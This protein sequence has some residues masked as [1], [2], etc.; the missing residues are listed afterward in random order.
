MNIEQIGDCSLEDR[1]ALGG[2]PL[3]VM[4]VT[5][6]GQKTRLIREE[7]RRVAEDHRDAK[8]YEV[9]LLENPSVTEKYSILNPPM[10]LMFVD[11]VE[12]GRHAGTFIATTIDR[13]LGPCAHEED[14][15]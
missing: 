11:G 6:E 9:D 7:F 8:F 5:S 12:V 14:E 4:F 15:T 3:V 10:T 2:R 13:V 1:L